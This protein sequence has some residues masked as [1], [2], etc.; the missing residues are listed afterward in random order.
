[1]N[2][3]FINSIIEELKHR[4]PENTSIQYS[5]VRKNNGVVLNALSILSEN[6]TIAPVIYLDEIADEVDSFNELIKKIMEL[7]AQGIRQARPFGDSINK[8]TSWEEIKKLVLP[9]VVNYEMNL[10]FLSNVPHYQLEDL[11]VYFYIDLRD[12]TDKATVTITQQLLMKLD[13]SFEVLRKQAISNAYTHAKLSNMADLLADMGLQIDDDIEIPMWV[14]TMDNK[15]FGASAILLDDIL[16][17]LA[18]MLDSNLYILP[19]SIYE[20]IC[21]STNYSDD[22]KVLKSMVCAVNDEEVSENDFLSNNVYIFDRDC[23]TV[24]ICK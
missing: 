11:A 4:Y 18:D 1:M 2:K 19:S 23:K 13:V 7:N 14:V 6:Q 21:I 9:K 12:I 20:I 10:D 22:Y 15:L 5:E 16:S 3:D 24:S 8:L 17:S